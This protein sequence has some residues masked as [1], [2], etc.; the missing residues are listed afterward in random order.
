MGYTHITYMH[1]AYS[2][3]YNCCTFQAIHLRA[4]VPRYEC[5]VRAALQQRWRV[6]NLEDHLLKGLLN[7]LPVRDRGNPTIISIPIPNFC[8]L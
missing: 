6:Q 4:P 2:N 7:A 8:Y 3:L 1:A 5:W